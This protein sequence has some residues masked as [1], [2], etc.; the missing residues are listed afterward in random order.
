MKISVIIP[1][2]NCEKEISRLLDSIV[3]QKWGKEDLEVIACDDNSTDK[4]MEIVK[5]Y[6]DKLNII[7]CR[8]K[9]REIH[10]PGNTRR[11]AME[12]ASGEWI[13]FID[14]DDEFE[15]D[16]FSSVW[17]QIEAQ[18]ASTVMCCR[19][20]NVNYFNHSLDEDIGFND[21]WLHGKFYN[22]QFLNKYNINFK[23]NLESHE[24]IYFNTF[25]IKEIMKNGLQDF[26]YFD[27]IVYHWIY[28]PNSLSRQYN[29][30]KY[31]YIETYF[32]DYLLA[33]SYQYLVNIQNEN[34][35]DFYLHQILITILHGYFYLQAFEY[36][37][38]NVENDELYLSNYKKYKELVFQV[39]ETYNLT[40]DNIINY[41]YSIPELYSKIR[42]N[43]IFGTSFFIEKSSF[44]DFLK[45][46]K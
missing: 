4:C 41:I 43:C 37:H 23:E 21:T 9:E 15:N 5:S 17:E 13:T 2:Y 40:L 38:Q 6:K 22:K 10:C 33:S 3:N 31:L 18:K 12:Y 42:K 44:S 29:N 1:I 26:C 19:M 14:N 16:V 27:K 35:F 45:N 39:L 20:R 8:T 46:L 24:D 30:E 7:C 36:R 25:V 11:D 28:R 34:A 32:S